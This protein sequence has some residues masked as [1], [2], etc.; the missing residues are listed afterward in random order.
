MHTL[1]SFLSIGLVILGALLTLRLLPHV[2]SWS[3]R[4]RTQLFILLMPLVSIGLG[5][6]GLHHLITSFCLFITPFWDTLFGV[7]LPLTMGMVVL[8]ALC[9][10]V[11]RL[12]LMAYVVTRYRPWQSSTL[13][14]HAD[15]LSHQFRTT[16]VRVLL[17]TRERPLAF[18]YGVLRPT[19]LLSTW[20]VTQLDLR[21][22][23]AVLTHELEHV[24]RRDYLVVWL[25][26]MLRD[27]FFYLPTSRV[28]YRQLQQE[29]ELACD[30]MAVE[31]THRPLALASALT[32]VWLHAIE[33]PQLA[34]VGKAQALVEPKALITG[35]IERLLASPASKTPDQSS[36]GVPFGIGA[37][38]VAVLLIV[39][40]VNMMIM[41]SLMG[42]N[43]IA[44]L[45]RLF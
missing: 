31:V 13:Q 19:V 33:E 10:G 14:E 16:R 29:K 3:L 26:T 36:H 6:D 17:C 1:L 12:A 22:I 39:Q 15:S 7:M 43:P 34:R 24:A 44:L 5:I 8:G 20:M 23:E 4:R 21:E 2:R 27:A 41:F 38:I 25:A 9:L 30:D 11:I 18:T 35:R 40:A 37:L 28:A 45:Q 32:K 42:C